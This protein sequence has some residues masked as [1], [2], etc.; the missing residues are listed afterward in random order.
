RRATSRRLRLV[1]PALTL[2]LRTATDALRSSLLAAS[3]GRRPIVV[4]IVVVIVASFAKPSHRGRQRLFDLVALSTAQFAP[5]ARHLL[6]S[7]DIQRA[8]AIRPIDAGFVDASF[9]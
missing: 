8:V 6:G 5:I 2:A 9:V 7:G 4:V 1:G 3:S